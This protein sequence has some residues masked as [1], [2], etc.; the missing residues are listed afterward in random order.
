MQNAL[1]VSLKNLKWFRIRKKRMTA[2]LLLLSL[3]VTLNVFWFLRQPGLTLAGDASC[4]IVEHTHDETCGTR[5]CI[6]TIPEGP[7]SHED[8]CYTTNWI[9]AQETLQLVCDITEDPHIHS[10]SCYATVT[11]ESKE[12]RLICDDQD[13]GH[14]HDEACYEIVVTDTWEETEL[15][16]NLVSE[17]HRH[18]ESCYAMTRIEAHEEQVLSCGL[19]EEGHIHSDACY[20]WNISCE[21]E[22]HV[23]SIDCYS[24]DTADVETILDW[25][26]MF[27][28]YPYTGNLREDLVGIAKTQVGYS[29]STLNFEVGSDGIRRGYTRYGAWYGTPYRDWSAMFVSF[30]LHYAGADPEETPGNT[31]ASAMATLWERLDKYVPAGDYLPLGGD[32]VFFSN[33]TVGIVSEVQNA[34]FRVIRGDMDDAVSADLLTLTDESI[35]GWGSTVGTTDNAEEPSE[36]TEAPLI[37]TTEEEKPPPAAPEITQQDLLDISEGP[38]FFIFASGQIPAEMQRY[39]LRNS[40]AIT[41]LLPYLEANGGNYFFTLLDFN[42]VELPKDENGNYIATAGTGYKLTLTFTSP[43]GFLPGTYQYQIPNGLMV[44]GGEGT[45]ILKDGTEVGSWVVTDTGLITLV[46]NEHMNSRTDITISATLGIHFPEQEEPIDF[47]GLISVKVEKPPPQS[48]PTILNKWGSQSTTDPTKIKWQLNITGQADSQIIGNII[49]DQ[50]YHGEWSKPHHYTASDIAGGLTIGASDPDGGWHN[51]RVS[52]D[53]PHLIWDETGWS[54]KMPQTVFCDYCGEIE[55]G[56]DGWIYYI[57]YTSTPDRLSA[58]GTYGY[59][60]IARIDGQEKWGWVNFTHGEADAEINKNGTFVSD[61]SG[62]RF[63]WEVQV[64]IPGRGE[65]E[66]AKY[67]W[68][69]MDE[70]KLLD[71]NGVSIGPVY[72]DIGL[73]RVTAT[74]NGTTI[75][76]P[77]LQDA[78]DA[79]MF[80]WENAWTSDD[81]HT[82]TINILSRCQCTHDSCFWDYS[83]NSCGEYWYQDDAGNWLSTQE[84]CQCWTETQTVVFNFIYETNDT[85]LIQ[86]Y[87]ILRHKLNNSAQLYYMPDGGNSNRVD[88]DDATVEIPNLFE[89]QLT[90]DYDGYTANYRVT[91]NEAKINLTNGSPLTIHD[92]MSDTLAYISGSLVITAE[93]AA[94]NT[95]TLQQGADFTVAYDGT[96]NQTDDHGKEVHVLDIVILHPQPVMYTLDYDATLIFPEH[97]AEGIRYSNS[98]TITLWGE[99]IKDTTVEKVYADINL[100]AKSYKVR[101]FKTS[102]QTGEPLGGA[103]FGLYNEQ[104]GLITTEVTDANGE[105]LFQT[106]IVEGIILREH[107]P[108]YMQELKAPPGYQLDDTKHWFCFCDN[109]GDSCEICDEVLAGLDAIRIPFEQIGKV[110]VTNQIMHYDL[111][112]TGG[113]GVYPLILVSVLFIITPLVYRF[114]LR[115]KRERRGVG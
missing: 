27:A 15:I 22:E 43:E 17:P 104:G 65:G 98:A 21:R 109:T 40:R 46:F 5:V 4:G 60:N 71:E 53:D 66:K 38:A 74:Y 103:T 80:A 85:E 32:L 36:P 57:E 26:E 77:R 39:S 41:D 23:H 49:T 42:N 24:D 91:V 72:N 54:Y 107:I 114:V 56:N 34:T 108:Y 6:C 58:P 102:A 19:L 61:G 84:F 33:N 37:E 16:C 28:D 47:D 12:N 89:K 87:G 106:S 13:E 55:L 30:C 93:D 1:D 90:H 101:M 18:V 48:Y 69:F 92:V 95:Y 20:E 67:S 105:L 45:F 9:E 94:G 11:K 111:P 31:G 64:V 2:T 99:D 115:R 59:E 88:T 97:V 79:D 25:Q 3:V 96:G 8:A 76:V 82:R 50:V 100:V 44:D 62:G 78:T 52:A 51:W 86:Q 7:H 35:V 73:S 68:F 83:N 113:S 29:E 81:G 75:D 70:M 110:N 10:D 63:L 14:L 112:A